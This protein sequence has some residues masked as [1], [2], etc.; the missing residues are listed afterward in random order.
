MLNFIGNLKDHYVQ[1]TILISVLKI[2]VLTY[3]TSYKVCVLTLHENKAENLPTSSQLGG[4]ILHFLLCFKFTA[5]HTGTSTGKPG[6]NGP[7]SP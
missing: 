3:L 2:K 7:K 5:N 6:L 4:W 1:K